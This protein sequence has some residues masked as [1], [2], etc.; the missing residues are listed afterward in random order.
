MVRSA[1]RFLIEPAR[2]MSR[3]AREP[4][5]SCTLGREE[6]IPKL[7]VETGVTLKIPLLLIESEYRRLFPAS[8]P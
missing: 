3:I 1:D 4:S 2:I 6:T 8:P 7:L 5:T